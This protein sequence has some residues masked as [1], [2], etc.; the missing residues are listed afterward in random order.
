MTEQRFIKLN[1][2]S[3][4]KFDRA[5]RSPRE[6]SPDYLSDLYIRLIDDLSYA[7]THYPQSQLNDYL[8]DLA[9]RAHAFIHG[10]KR[11]RR[12]RIKNLY[13]REIPQAVNRNLGYFRTAFIVF[14]ACIAIGVL[15]SY[16][17]PRF[18]RMIL[19]DAYV[20]QTLLNIEM[21]D[22]MA[23][24]KSMNKG[25]MFSRIAVNNVRVAFMAFIMGVGFGVPTIFILL[26]NG[27]MVG[28]FLSFFAQKQLLGVAMTTIFL[29][30][31]MEL[32]AI[33]ISAAAGLV[34]GTRW[35]FPGTFHRSRKLVEGAKD[36]LKIMIGIVPFIVFAAAIES[37]VTRYYLEMPSWV[38]LM[39]ILVT[40]A[41]TAWYFLIYPRKFISDVK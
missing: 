40:F 12:N 18:P 29:H 27:V 25:S 37:Y 36:G 33:V 5:L 16:L 8:N 2:E 31:A 9:V 4:M 28:G 7:R 20:N 32:S 1:R 14:A 39:I 17:D 38:R 21:G 10:T 11:E 41:A 23:V 22:P 35:L 26:S 3:W 6:I 34:M 13:V 30:G 24:Y 19:G 15:S